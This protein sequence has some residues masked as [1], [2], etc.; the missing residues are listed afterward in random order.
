LSK[1]T[2]CNNGLHAFISENSDITTRNGMP[3]GLRL[4]LE[5]YL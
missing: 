2:M 1:V 3:R 4:L 5:K